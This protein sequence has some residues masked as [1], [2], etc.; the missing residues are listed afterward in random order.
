MA[1]HCAKVTKAER[2]ETYDESMC[3][4]GFFG[5]TLMENY[6]DCQYAD[7]FT[8]CYETQLDLMSQKIVGCDTFARWNYEL[9]GEGS[10][11]ISQETGRIPT[12]NEKIVYQACRAASRWRKAGRE[13]IPVLVELPVTDLFRADIDDFIGKCLM[14]FQVEPTS[15]I[16][17]IDASIVRLDW[18]TCSKQIKKIKELGVKVCVFNMDIG[19]THLEFLSGLPV[20][21][22]KLH[23]SFVHGI[24]SSPENLDKC[25]KI[26]D[27]AGAIGAQ[28]MFEGVDKVDQASALQSIHTKI[29]VQGRYTGKP[30]L[31]DDL[32]RILPEYIERRLSESTVILDENDFAKGNYDLF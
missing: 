9:S 24:D 10:G 1:R 32:T 22:I 28:A 15:L 5:D 17:K 23:R 13:A 14:E 20:D 29:I 27:R 18:Y 25:R 30:A 19:Y 26:V 11:S 21:F 3:S 16:V 4:S 8:V 12:N 31:A 6:S 7:D 2:F